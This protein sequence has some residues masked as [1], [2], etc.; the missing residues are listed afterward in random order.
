MC[1]YTDLKNLKTINNMRITNRV[2]AFIS[3]SILCIGAVSCKKDTTL[4]YYNITMGNVT[5][6]R[7]TSDQG[8][9]FNVVEQDKACY[10]KLD[11]MKRVIILCDVLNKTTG[12]LDNEYD[13]RLN[14]MSSVKVKDIILDGKVED[15]EAKSPEESTD[16]VIDE[17]VYKEDPV[18]IN[19][20]WISGGYINMLVQL[21]FKQ[22]SKTVHEINLLKMETE[23][24][25]A[26]RL[27]HNANGETMTEST[28]HA[29]VEGNGY[30]SFPISSIITEDEAEVR[31]E[32][33]WYKVLGTS[34]D[35]NTTGYYYTEFTY[36][37]G[38]EHIPAGLSLSSTVRAM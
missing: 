16:E 6:G 5:E 12:G 23:K 25:Y 2:I 4:Q 21:P 31:F 29:F 18:T 28:M 38:Y 13:I 20:V 17:N 32:W 10:G 35:I 36:K 27:V 22:S 24:G 11:T 19:Q 7:F 8:N 34:I 15:I 1:I 3:A 33:K 26:F 37:K 9:I 14:A 30:F